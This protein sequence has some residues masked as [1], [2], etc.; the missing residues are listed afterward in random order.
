MN[1]PQSARQIDS[2][3]ATQGL[4]RK[5][6]VEAGQESGEREGPGASQ[7]ENGFERRRARGGCELRGREM[8][9]HGPTASEKAQRRTPLCPVKAAGTR[10]G[11]TLHNSTERPCPP[12]TRPRLF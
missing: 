6:N 11:C 5:G 4:W 10:L 1:Q 12:P 2:L 7:E 9:S 3:F 8:R